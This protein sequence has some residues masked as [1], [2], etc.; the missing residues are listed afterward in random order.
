MAANG[1]VTALRFTAPTMAT[2]SVCRHLDILAA[3]AATYPG[4]KDY[5]LGAFRLLVMT[6]PHRVPALVASVAEGRTREVVFHLAAYYPADRFTA[7][8]DEVGTTVRAC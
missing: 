7:H 3:V 5:I 2:P 4:E 6:E 8:Q 1:F